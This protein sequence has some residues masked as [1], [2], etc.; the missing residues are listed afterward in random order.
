MPHHPW[1]RLRA[2]R[3]DVEVIW[4]P[5]P[6]GRLAATDGR[7][8]YM[9][10]R[11][12]QVQRRCAAAHETAHIDLGHVKGCTGKEEQAARALAA[13]RLVAMP[14]LLAAYQ[15][16]E[17]LEEVADELWVTLDVLRDRLDNLTQ[18]ERDEL[19]ALYAEMERPC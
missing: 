14:Q 3:D 5:Q 12:S 1:R 2:L 17:E 6:P 7:V 9:D 4:A 18:D 19:V 16:A 10:P 15:W 8:I 13:R 11:M